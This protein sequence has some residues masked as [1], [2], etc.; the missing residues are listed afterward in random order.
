MLQET[1]TY[2]VENNSPTYCCFLDNTKAFDTVWHDGLFYK[3]H[4]LGISGKA[5]RV[6]CQAYKGMVNHVLYEGIL[7]KPVAVMQS[8]RQGSVLGPWFWLIYI[9]DCILE[10]EDLGHGARVYNIYCG[11]PIQADDIVL[12]SVT[13]NGLQCMVAT[14]YSYSCLWRLEFHPLKSCIIIARLN[15]SCKINEEFKW[16]LG[17]S[18]IPKSDLH[19]HVGILQSSN[20]KTSER[21][22]G[23]CNKLRS[24]YASLSHSSLHPLGLNPLSALKLYQTVCL[25]AA[26]YGCEIWGTLTVKEL[27]SLEKVHRQCIK[28]MQ[29]LPTITRTDM[30]LGM[31]GIFS[32]ESYID[33]CRLKFMGRLCTTK[34]YQLAKE[35]F[36]FLATRYNT[37]TSKLTLGY[38]PEIVRVLNKYNLLNYLTVYIHGGTF[39]SKV[40][41]KAIV[42]NRVRIVQTNLTMS[43]M[44][45]DVDF[46]KFLKVV[47]SINLPSKFWLCVRKYPNMLSKVRR[48]VIEFTGTDRTTGVFKLCENCGMF[49][50]DN[51][52]HVLV[53]CSGYDTRRE[54][55]WMNLT[56]LVGVHLAEVV[57]NL[58]S[59]TQVTNLLGADNTV[60]TDVNTQVDAIKLVAQFMF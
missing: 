48:L 28:R 49:Y 23:A 33:E 20:V 14:S 11:S 54:Q 37:S 55:L 22:T 24:T 44:Q 53:V 26:L 60:L 25:P 13:P 18:E 8:I 12:I 21:T 34:C 38:V 16:F 9:N 59:D 29:G 27:D 40:Q 3:L 2:N 1:V 41:W 7:S 35:V 30:A 4:K 17:N 5:W 56:N 15:K 36:L 6:L 52:Q 58:D 45:Y 50:Q 39:P 46:T 43:R 19:K 51:L 32:L 31:M 42:K 57:Y 47:N 10:L